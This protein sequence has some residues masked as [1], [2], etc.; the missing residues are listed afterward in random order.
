MKF[1][2]NDLVYRKKAVVNW[3]GKCN[4]VLANE[5]VHNGKCWRHEDTQVEVKNLNQWYLKT[6]EYAD[7]LNDMSQLQQWPEVIQKLQ[8]NWI[9]ESIGTEVTFTINNEPWNVFTLEYPK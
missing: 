8:K 1:L 5:Q 9:G 2:E 7:Q 3:C 4:T 6:T